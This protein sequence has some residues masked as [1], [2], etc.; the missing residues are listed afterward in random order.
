MKLKLI[1]IV[2]FVFYDLCNVV[3]ASRKRRVEEDPKPK[4]KQVTK[5]MDRITKKM[6]QGSIRYIDTS[7][8]MHKAVALW[9]AW[10]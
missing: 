3:M 8:V 9:L 10:L 5:I 6:L 4:K 7:V 1:T 2:F